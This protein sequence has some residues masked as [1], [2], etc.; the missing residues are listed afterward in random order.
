[1]TMSVTAPTVLSKFESEFG[2]LKE[3]L[4]MTDKMMKDMLG[5]GLSAS[6]DDS[7]HTGGTL[8]VKADPT[9]GLKIVKIQP[10]CGVQSG[11][12]GLTPDSEWRRMFPNPPGYSR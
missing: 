8:P 6:M 2:K 3:I 5:E 10:S 12:R 9:I 1:M 11:A 4:A 7:E